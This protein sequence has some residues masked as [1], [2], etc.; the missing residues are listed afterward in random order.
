MVSPT[1]LRPSGVRYERGRACAS[2]SKRAV[3]GRRRRQNELNLTYRVLRRHPH[4]GIGFLSC[5]SPFLLARAS[6]SAR[7]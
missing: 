7:A 3:V 2:E 5:H 1:P 6:S 4:G